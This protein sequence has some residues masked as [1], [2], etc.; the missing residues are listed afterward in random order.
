MK[1]TYRYQKCT[2][3]LLLLGVTS[4]LFAAPG[5][6]EI[7]QS[8]VAGGC[9]SSDAAGFPIEIANT[10]SYR[11]TSNIVVGDSATSAIVISGRDVELDLNGFTVSGPVTCS[12]TPVTSCT[13]TSGGYG[14]TT[15]SA[16]AYN[17]VVKNGFV[18]GFA[19]NGIRL[20]APA[21][22]HDVIVRSNGNEG[23]FINVGGAA[24]GNIRGASIRNAIVKGNGSTGIAASTN[25]VSISESFVGDNG[26]GGITCDA[27]R[28]TKNIV[29]NNGG[30]GIT[31]YATTGTL[32][33]HNVITNNTSYGAQLTDGSN[34]I[35]NVITG[36]TLN[37]ILLPSG[38]IG[39]A[40]NILSTGTGAQISGAPGGAVAL[41][42]N[43][44]GDNTTCP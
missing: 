23:I 6:L 31:S 17:A 27:C 8:C 5:V 19:Q 26:S 42:A 25:I 14:I 15:N 40:Q 12:G 20:S 36:N 9:L 4:P 39:Y 18:R 41:G 38:I 21:V 13:A 29:H 11:L 10:G 37:S 34:L 24:A 2:L 22:V 35:G 7:D 1:S 3:S 43:Y 32:L 33:E 16:D 30:T 44:C 28:L